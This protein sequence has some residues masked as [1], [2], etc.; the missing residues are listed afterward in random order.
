MNTL[1]VPPTQRD[2]ERG[3]AL[4]FV[5]IAM[6]MLVAL[7]VIGV[8]VGRLAF[9]AAETQSIADAAATAAAGAIGAHESDPLAVATAVVQQNYVDA[10]S[11]S[12]GSGATDVVKSIT[13]GVWDFE[14]RTFKA[15]T[16]NDPLVNAARARAVATVDNLLAA[17][18]GFVQSDVERQATAAAGGACTE[19]L[20]FP[21][22]IEKD[23]IQQYLDSTDCRNIDP[24]R[25]FQVPVDN[26][27]FTSLSG[28]SASADNEKDLVPKCG[29][30]GGGGRTQ[31]V[32]IDDSINLDN[33]QQTTVLQ[34][35]ED[36]VKAGQNEFVVPVVADGGC[37]PHAADVI[38]FARIIIDHV[39]STG[40]ASLKGIYIKGVCRETVS[41]TNP[42][43][44]TGGE[45][46]M[47][48]VN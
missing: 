42:G 38:A 20:A 10:R 18:I 45:N 9:T 32:S 21:V 47:A 26:S 28:D 39:Q 31:T 37:G 41:G 24:T 4:A 34:A 29:S 19:T 12:V 30:G 7:A 5:G 36:C 22:A 13:P 33:G 48:I 8:D 43:C 3:Q 14:T 17:M 2:R 16:W 6:I 44:L 11:G 25:L 35:I 15:S 46:A 1:L 23:A 27:C 40:A